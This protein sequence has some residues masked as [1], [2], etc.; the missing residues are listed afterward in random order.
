MPRIVAYTYDADVWCVSCTQ[1]RYG[2]ECNTEAV[3]GRTP[4][5][6]LMRGCPDCPSLDEHGIPDGQV[7]PSGAPFTL[8]DSEGNP[9]RPVFSTDEL[10]LTNCGGCLTP[11]GSA[12]DEMVRVTREGNRLVIDGLPRDTRCGQCGRAFREHDVFTCP[13]G[14][15]Q[16][17]VLSIFADELAGGRELRPDDEFTSFDALIVQ[18]GGRSA[19]PEPVRITLPTQQRRTEC[20]Y[21]GEQGHNFGECPQSERDRDND[22]DG[23]DNDGPEDYSYEESSCRCVDCTA[24]YSYQNGEVA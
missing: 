12:I 8:Y 1:S 10:P 6:R 18:A 13:D 2:W 24:A 9:V 16:G 7:G 21:C 22:Y 11:L 17:F 19:R 3:N 23:P 4:T 5:P 20:S 15:P 14:Q